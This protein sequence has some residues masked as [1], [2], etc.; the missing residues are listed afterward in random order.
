MCK[1]R[2]GWRSDVLRIRN[3]L[4]IEQPEQPSPSEDSGGTSNTDAEGEQ[5]QVVVSTQEQARLERV[6]R[7]W[8]QDMGAPKL[9]LAPMIG[10][11]DLAFRLL[12]RE[13]GVTLCYTQM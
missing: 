7:W 11:S 3:G 12:C 9:V 10:Q 8:R 5:L 4:V 6:W 13:N 2:R 1:W